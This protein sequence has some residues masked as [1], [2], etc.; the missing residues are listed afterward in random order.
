MPAA[1]MVPAALGGTLPVVTKEEV[2]DLLPDLS[3]H[4]GYVLDKVEGL[5]IM[6]DGTVWVVDRQ[7]RGRRPFGRDDVLVVPAEL[8]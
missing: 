2:R 4:G 7:R 3:V 5:A 6:E 1:A 8:R